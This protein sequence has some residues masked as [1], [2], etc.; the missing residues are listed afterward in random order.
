MAMCVFP[1]GMVHLN[2]QSKRAEG[3]VT[4][5]GR[6]ENEASPSHPGNWALGGATLDSSGG[7]GY[8]ISNQP[9]RVLNGSEFP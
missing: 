4:L 5:F 3:S 2:P 9:Q 1:E 7:V 6:E 8:N